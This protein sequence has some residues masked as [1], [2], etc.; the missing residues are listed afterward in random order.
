M[1]ISMPVMDGLEAT[2]RIRDVDIDVPIVALTA[3]ALKGDSETYLARGMNDYVAKPVHRDQL[4]CML[5]K[6]MGT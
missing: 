6:W 4:V 5:W 2:S 1:D 3:N